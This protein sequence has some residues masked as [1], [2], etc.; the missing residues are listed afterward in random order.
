MDREIQIG[1]H[2]TQ[3]L[4]ASHTQLGIEHRA[5]ITVHAGAAG[6]NRMNM[7][8]GGEIPGG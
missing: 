4:R 3:A 1:I 5:L 2:D 8:G 6:G 7:P